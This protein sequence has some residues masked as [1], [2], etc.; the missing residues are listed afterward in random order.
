MLTKDQ[1]LEILALNSKTNRHELI[2]ECLDEYDVS[3]TEKLT[4]EQLSKFCQKR[5]Y[6]N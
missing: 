1:Y 2:L 6:N 3:S 5:N 4:L